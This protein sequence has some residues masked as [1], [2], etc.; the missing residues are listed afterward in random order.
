MCHGGRP[1]SG[2]L[3]N[4]SKLPLNNLTLKTERGRARRVPV[5][6]LSSPLGCLKYKECVRTSKQCSF[7]LL[8]ILIQHSVCVLE[9]ANLLHSSNDRRVYFHYTALPT[10]QCRTG[11]Y[12]IIQNLVVSTEFQKPCSR[13]IPRVCVF[14]S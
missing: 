10:F 1:I 8:Q 6:V 11:F 14:V 2:T 9:L 3:I 5:W 12:Y 4:D 13:F 7:G